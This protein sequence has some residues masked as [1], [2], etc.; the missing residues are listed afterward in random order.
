MLRPYQEDTLTAIRT[1][2]DNGCSRQVVSIACGG[3]K[4]QIF[5]HLPE[6]IKDRLPLRTLVLAHRSELLDQ[7]IDK[8]R[9]ANPALVI[10]K[11]MGGEVAD[12]NADIIVASTAT[13]GRDGSKKAER[14]DWN[15]ID[16]IITDECHRATSPSYRR[17]YERSGVLDTNTKKL[18]VGFTATPQ[19]TD[20]AGLNAIYDK[21][22][23][24]YGLRKAIEDGWL[25]KVRG[26]KMTT[27]TDISKVGMSGEDFNKIE[28]GEAIDSPE[29]NERVVKFWQLR[30]GGRK[31]VVYAAGI[32]HAQHLAEAFQK[33]GIDARSV[34]GEDPNRK[35]TLIWHRE[36]AGSVLVNAQLLIEGYD[37]PSISCI[38]I[39]APTA[40]S[41]KFTQECGRATR[42]FPGKT[43]CIILV[44]EDISD[45]HS[46]ITLPMLMGLPGNLDLNG[47]G[48]VE[49][50]EL[51]EEMQEQNPA[52]DFSKLKTIDGIK[53][54]IEEINLFEVRFPK[55]V[56]SN[57]D[58]SWTKAVDGS[59]VMKVPKLPTDTT[60]WKAGKVRIFQNLL[61]KWE[62]DGIIDQ[63]AFHGTRGSI[64]E[65]FACA[66]QQIR[67]RAP[68]SVVLVN[69][70][71]GWTTKPATK[72][73]M[74][75][76][77]RLYGKG[78]VWPEGFTAGQA[79][80]WIDKRIGGR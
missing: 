78:K 16:K 35:E 7:A 50:V 60:D 17:I 54:F 64:E 24:V 56:E 30:A 29:R 3:G 58:F 52:I 42:L 69:R 4:T 6:F 74:T 67:E 27:S 15:S 77:S 19:R 22:V 51:I 9:T 73:Q 1:A 68:A 11:E 80:F 34:Y 65:A 13:L 10:S 38:V 48:L 46:L 70:K 26:Y 31:T 66:D 61:D 44:P 36:T 33:A 59:F 12:V 55:E 37:D 8:L 20:G 53:H 14:F 25:V 43:D 28:L 49:A 57:S 18:H 75:M 21:I 62:I 76:L 72:N 5:A 23:Y 32:S 40:S 39:A 71:A 47:R 45:G 79:S 2:Y 41:V 63:K